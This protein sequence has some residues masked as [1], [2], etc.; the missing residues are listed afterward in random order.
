M[1]TE[2]SKQQTAKAGASPGAS[3][4]AKKAPGSKKKSAKRGAAKVTAKP[5]TKKAPPRKSQSQ[6]KAVDVK[7]QGSSTVAQAKETQAKETQAKEAGGTTSRLADTPALSANTP[8]G[9]AKRDGLSWFAV[10]AAL[11]A[12]VLAGYAAYQGTVSKQLGDISTKGLD[13]RVSLLLTDQ[14]GLKREFSELQQRGTAADAQ[15]DTR[16][17]EIQQ[18]LGAQQTTL[19]K[20]QLASQASTDDIKASLG[21][22]VARWKLDEMQSILVRVNQYYQLGGDQ[23][24]AI[25]GLELVRDMLSGID[26]PRLAVVSEGVAQDML[27]I[28][29]DALPDMAE[30]NSRLIALSA[31][32]PKLTLAG[33]A[34]KPAVVNEDTK[35]DDSAEGS[36]LDAS[37]SLL[38]DIGSMVKYTNRDA[39]LRPSL[40]SNE[41]FILYE[42]LQLKLQIAMAG[43][44]RGDD[45]V[46]QAQLRSAS[47]NISAYFEPGDSVTESV[48]KELKALLAEHVSLEVDPLSAALS[49]LN[50]VMILEK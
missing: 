14:Q 3:A 27:R 49:A 29:S 21:S 4:T 10:A 24:R 46:Y 48:Q 1:S 22:A 5:A 44:M 35:A 11:L 42:L 20:V 34:A 17:N 47:E 33:E 12:L 36:L 39:P 8:S 37:R 19:E 15:R 50:R 32:I 2:K 6:D 41:R 18:Q 13:E 45:A 7:T 9:P 26:D 40:D 31:L 25:Q 43:L 23:S 38:E 16:L 28:Q 30:I